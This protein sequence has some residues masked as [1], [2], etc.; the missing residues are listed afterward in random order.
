MTENPLFITSCIFEDSSI[1]D[2]LR[3]VVIDLENDQCLEIIIDF[4]KE[5]HKYLEK[6][7]PYNQI[8]ELIPAILSCFIH[9]PK[10]L[11]PEFD[12]FLSKSSTNA[13]Y[14]L[15]IVTLI[16]FYT[17]IQPKIDIFNYIPLIKS[18]INEINTQINDQSDKFIIFN[19]QIQPQF[20][21]NFILNTSLSL[22]QTDDEIPSILFNYIFYHNYLTFNPKFALFL[23][24]FEK[25]KY[26]KI[27]LQTDSSN[28]QLLEFI[29]QKDD[30]IFLKMNSESFSIIECAISY[31]NSENN[32]KIEG[33][34]DETI[35]PFLAVI[36]ILIQKQRFK[37]TFS[38]QIDIELFHNAVIKNLK[39]DT[40]QLY[41]TSIDIIFFILEKT[42]I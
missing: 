21:N 29:T 27:L 41:N 8:S 18:I 14:L 24:D 9:F 32:N 10:E 40:N 6:Q 39:K 13:N 26:N 34:T 5:S 7:L 30:Q 20:Q 1:I 35:I 25:S 38:K 31:L 37:S 3:Q 15:I 19:H 11:I 12:I 16:S 42:Q 23:Q 33:L 36:S 28:S 4:L 17:H 22:I 2:Q